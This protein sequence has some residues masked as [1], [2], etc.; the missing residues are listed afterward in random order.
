MDR[1]QELGGQRDSEITALW[2]RKRALLDQKDV[3]TRTQ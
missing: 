3:L 1:L 2:Q